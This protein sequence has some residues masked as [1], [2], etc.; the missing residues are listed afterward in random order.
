VSKYLS[1]AKISEGFYKEKGSKFFE[2]I[3]INLRKKIIFINLI[4][5]KKD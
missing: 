1:I 5:K 4:K 3:Q 2:N